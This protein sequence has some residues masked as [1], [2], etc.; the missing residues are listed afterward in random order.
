LNPNTPY[1]Q[2]PNLRMHH[3]QLASKIKGI[4]F[5]ATLN[6]TYNC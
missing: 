3:V 6:N 4:D 2:K 5:S 1:V